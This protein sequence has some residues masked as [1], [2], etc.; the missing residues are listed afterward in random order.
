MTRRTLSHAKVFILA[1]VA[2]GQ[3]ALA[4]D[5]INANVGVTVD[6]SITMNETQSMNFG[7]FFMTGNT[8][9]EA[10]GT[11]AVAASRTPG[12]SAWLQLNFDGTV[13]ATDGTTAKA[14]TI[15]AS[16]QV[17][18]FDISGAAFNAP[19]QLSSTIMLDFDS[20]AAEEDVDGAVDTDTMN[21]TD[22]QIDIDND[23]VAD[24]DTVGDTDA[25]VVHATTDGTGALQIRTVGR[26]YSTYIGLADNHLYEAGVFAG[27]YTLNVSY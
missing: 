15:G 23:N 4:T 8:N 10:A 5:T 25:G 13:T 14:A 7:T 26:L 11:G 19:I 9:A 1:L 2:I 6:A 21:F 16:A 24:N 17:G 3:N 12:D 18:V 22:L 20:T 27:T